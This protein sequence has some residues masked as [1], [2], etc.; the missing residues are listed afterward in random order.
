MEHH[1]FS[2]ENPLFRLG[3]FQC[4]PAMGD[5]L[6][7]T[8]AFKGNVSQDIP[9]FFNRKLQP[10]HASNWGSWN[11]TNIYCGSIRWRTPSTKTT[12]TNQGAL[13]PH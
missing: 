10:Y 13:T 7:V 4:L 5:F 8:G 11:P 3:H 2:W 9:S 6:I 1:N 12:Q